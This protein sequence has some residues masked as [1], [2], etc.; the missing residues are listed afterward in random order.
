MTRI[1]G[2]MSHSANEAVF[3]P[4]VE[5]C[6]YG[7]S[8]SVEPSLSGGGSFLIYRFSCGLCVRRS[9]SIHVE[10]IIPL[11]EEAR[12]IF[13]VPLAYGN[14]TDGIYV[15]FVTGFRHTFLEPLL[16]NQGVYSHR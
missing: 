8:L 16:V 2:A 10:L 12:S 7:A 6:L 5:P 13:T 14:P 15:E 3:Y 1:L 9:C 4:W 11:L